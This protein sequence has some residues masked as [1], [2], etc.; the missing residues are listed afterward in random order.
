VTENYSTKNSGA[1][2]KLADNDDLKEEGQ[3]EERRAE[4]RS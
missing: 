3:D 4:K 1:P 2:D